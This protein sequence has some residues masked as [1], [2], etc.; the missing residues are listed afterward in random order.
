MKFRPV[1]LA[2]LVGL[3]PGA[4]DR[5]YKSRPDL[6]PPHLKITVP[7]SALV[8]EGYL[9][10][11]P[12]SHV[13]GGTPQPD[14]YIFD[15]TGELIWSGYG[16]FGPAASNFHPARWRGHGDVL[17]AFGGAMSWFRGHSHVHHKIVDSRYQTIREV[18]SGGHYPSDSHELNVVDKR[19][20]LVGSYSPHEIDLGPYGGE[21]TRPGFSSIYYRV[22]RVSLQFPIYSGRH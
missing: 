20:A 17:I 21:R 15:S 18:R 13:P 10:V 16:Y 4:A 6:S 22:G 2:G 3:Q 7:A 14:P 11:A 9:F 19:S 8:D 12:S 1:I 5:T